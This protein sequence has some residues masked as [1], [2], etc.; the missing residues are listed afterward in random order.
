MSFKLQSM[1]RAKD[2]IDKSIQHRHLYYWFKKS[3]IW[4]Q[5]PLDINILKTQILELGYEAVGKLYYYDMVG[6]DRKDWCYGPH[7]VNEF[8]GWLE[9]HGLLGEQIA[10][11][12]N[13]NQQRKVG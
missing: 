5:M 11:L 7:F 9:D 13:L 3:D 2:L 1:E 4:H 12:I 8:H 10:L 6:T